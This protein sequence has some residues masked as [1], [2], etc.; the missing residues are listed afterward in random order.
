[1]VVLGWA[2]GAGLVCCLGLTPPVLGQPTVAR[3]VLANGVTALVRESRTARVVAISL[4]VAAGSGSETEAT[5]GITSF[6]HRAMLRGTRHHSAVGLVEAAEDL[7]G[8][9]DASADV[10]HG[11]VR[12][13]GL[14]RNWDGLLALVA[15]VALT[16]TFPAEEVERE[17]RLLLGELDSRQ[18]SPSV[19]ALDALLA[20]LYGPHPYSW[21]VL[22]RRPAIETVTRDAL[23]AHHRAVFRPDRAV[24]AV[25]GDVSAPAVLR[26][27]ERRFGKWPRPPAEPERPTETARPTAARH[28]VE[29]PA[30]QAQVVV[31]FLGPALGQPDYAAVKVLT[32]LL[33]GGMGSRLFTEVRDKRG[34]A[35]AVGALNPS[36]RG[37]SAVIA[38]LGTAAENVEMAHGVIGREMDRLR[39]EPPGSEELA[40]A[41]AR[42]LGGLA[43]D[44]RTNARHAWHLAFFELV[45]LGWDFPEHHAR[46]VERV[47]AAEITAA[48]RRWLE[49]PTVVV[50]RP[51]RP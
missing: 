8:T 1:M 30:Q 44:R 40:R 11:E 2:M 21:P 29:K 41:K 13:Q 24:L 48:A 43:L 32:S 42:V 16:P 38:Y 45:G 10:D 14:A 7:G 22:G 3:Q 39:A 36:R 4:H 49:H 23:V 50:L 28:V 17:R 46:A 25:S 27:V 26:A 15:E 33:G 20:R 47:T 35:Y 31:G 34:L 37:P 19:A 9:V 6:V 12:A 51:P 5:A 18:D